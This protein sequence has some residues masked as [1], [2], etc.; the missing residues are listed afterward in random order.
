V[1]VAPVVAYEAVLTLATIGVRSGLVRLLVAS[2]QRDATRSPSGGVRNAATISKVEGT[3]AD[4]AFLIAQGLQPG[5][6]TTNVLSWIRYGSVFVLR[7]LRE[8]DRSRTW[9]LKAT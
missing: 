7:R 8:S 3:N 5:N 1:F 4:R 2:T 9:R 6:L